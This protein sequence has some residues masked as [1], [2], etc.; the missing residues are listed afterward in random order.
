MEGV[1]YF[2]MQRC[3]RL[4]AKIPTLA[5]KDAA[6]MGHPGSR[7]QTEVSDRDVLMQNLQ[8]KIP[9]PSTSSGQALS[10]KAREGWGTRLLL[11]SLPAGMGEPTGP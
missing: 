1:K 6:R 2:V 7:A 3:E 5:A 9:T 4:R 11:I 10:Q 8:V